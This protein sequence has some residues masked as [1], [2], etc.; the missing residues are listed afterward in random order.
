MSQTKAQL[1]DGKS[2]EIE[3]TGGSASGPAIS[4]TG[5]TN[6]GIYSPG[7]D[8]V[9]VATNGTGRLFIDASGN[10]GV[11]GSATDVLS[12]TRS[13]NS[14]GGIS[15]VNTNNAQA[16][17]ISQLYIQGGNN[18]HAQLKFS[19]NSLDTSIRGQGDGSLA[20]IQGVNERMRLDSA[21]L[22]GIGTSAPD[23]NL[24]IVGGTTT[25]GPGA[26]LRL[27][28][29]DQTIAAADEIIG[30]VTFKNNDASSGMT[31]YMA[32][33]D[34]ASNRIFD[35][36]PASGMNLRF[37]A[38]TAADGVNTPPE[39]MRLTSAGRLGIGT[40]A[41]SQ[42]LGV[43]GGVGIGNQLST[44]TTGSIKLTSSGGTNYIQSGQNTS[45]ASAAPLVFTDYNAFNEWARIDSSGRVGIGTSSPAVNL[46]V[47]AASDVTIALSNSS[48]VTSGN[49]GNISCFNSAVSSVG[50]IRFAAVTDNVGTEIQFHTRPA[51]GSLTQSMTLDS[52]GR[53]GVGTTTP[54]A[55]L[56][57]EQTSPV[58]GRLARIV[59]TGVGAGFLGVKSTGNTF[60]DANTLSTAL[61]FRTQDT[62]RA[63]IDSSGRLLI[64]TSTSISNDGAESALQIA[65]ATTTSTEQGFISLSMYPGTTNRNPRLYF[66]RSRGS[67]VGTN[68][69]V[70]ADDR[71]GEIFF[72]GADGTNLLAAA[73]IAAVS[74][75]TPG[76][77]DMPGRLVFSTTADGASSPTERMRIDSSGRV[78]IGATSPGSYE[79]SADNLVI[80]D[81]GDAGISIVSGASNT[82]NLFFASGTVGNDKFRGYIIYNHTNNALSFGTNAQERFRCDSSGRLLVGTSSSPS[83]TDGQ[84]AKIHLVG[85][86]AGATGDSVL[87]LGRGILASSGIAADTNLGILQFTDSAGAAH[88]T[89]KGVTDAATGSNDYPGRLVFSTTADG[90]SSPTER[91]R[92]TSN[93][94][95]YWATGSPGSSSFGTSI[96]R[97]GVPGLF[98][99]F[100][101]VDGG[102]TALFSGGSAGNAQIRGDGDLENTNN[103]YGGISDLKL[104]ENVVDASPQWD[105]L[106]A[107]QVRNYNFKAET[108]YNTHTQI[109]LIAQ[110][111]EL[112][113]PGLV[114]ESP[115]RDEDGNDLGTVTKSVNYSV[116]Y[117]KAVKA[118]QEAIAKIET[119]EGM[120]AVNN[121]TIDEQQH[122]LSTLAARLTALE[123]A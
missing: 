6:T 80:S 45:N 32:K 108:G 16:S 100:R 113:S 24:E 104:K 13:A 51:A 111:V 81:S 12:I 120:V 122:Q 99:T 56:H 112:V 105:D 21:G 7:A 54:Q 44:G 19:V 84:Y 123:S 3:F 2:A 37:F 110:E 36:D 75:G 47:N 79:V 72:T 41:P 76:A 87:N 35:G 109:G 67:S 119:L 114:G 4:F 93:G 117:M 27:S 58:D 63:R 86:T 97:N 14:A 74:D 5:D 38:G 57:L 18:A 42:T 52:T 34:A 62:E 8:Q 89:I 69:V 65:K 25:A 82:G 77:N 53:L 68:T 15:I 85:N 59:S 1:I 73:S 28:S 115:D 26:E 29:R 107:L 106:K 121:I 118:L 61:E 92:I 17:A 40:T 116:L 103:S 95:T 55:L 78:G 102:G 11:G 66:N 10:V 33:I 70:A 46:Q 98:E 91:M 96:G 50:V 101:N 20:I 23:S 94:Q 48:S 31:G 22:V 43:A 39:R 30:S 49:R 9:A 71:L 60:I 90:A 64:G 83:L 88:A